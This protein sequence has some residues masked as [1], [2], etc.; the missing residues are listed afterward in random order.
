MV[1]YDGHGALCLPQLF[2]T[3]ELHAVV[4][5]MHKTETFYPYTLQY[6]ASASSQNGTSKLS[7]KKIYFHCVF[8]F[9][10]L[11]ILFNS[12]IVL[13][14]RKTLEPHKSTLVFSAYI[15]IYPLQV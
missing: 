11:E 5:V 12:E 7:Y 1:R 15:N 10:D 2:E 9:S 3:G 4:L 6:H 13:S 14:N 8:K